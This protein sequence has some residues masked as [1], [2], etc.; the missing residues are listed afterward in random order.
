[1]GNKRHE[2]YQIEFML[3]PISEGGKVIEAVAACPPNRLR[4]V[5]DDQ[6]IPERHEYRRV[7]PKRGPF[8]GRTF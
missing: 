3:L 6:Q 1:M 5:S 4:H 8:M 2:R 7:F